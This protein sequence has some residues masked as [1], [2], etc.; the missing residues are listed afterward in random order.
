MGLADL[1]IERRSGI[2]QYAGNFLVSLDS[3]IIG[4]RAGMRFSKAEKINIIIISQAADPII[5]KQR[6]QQRVDVIL[7]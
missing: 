2:K 5:A 7:V 4:Q 6:R 3:S 1:S